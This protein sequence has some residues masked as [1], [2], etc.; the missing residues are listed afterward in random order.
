M[1]IG[2][3]I[4]LLTTGQPS[5]NPRLVKEADALVE[6]GYQVHVIYSHWADWASN[7]DR[8]LLHTREW[9]YSRVGGAPDGERARY[10]GSRLRHAVSRRA[11]SHGF[12]ARSRISELCLELLQSW[13]R[14][15]RN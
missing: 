14:L 15:R 4:C 5:T 8:E 11:R 10:W 7:T 13:K 9:T 2:T 6:D 12:G 3:K 1:S